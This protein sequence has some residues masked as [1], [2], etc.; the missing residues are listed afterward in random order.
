[1]LKRYSVLAFVLLCSCGT[2]TTQV[3]PVD[4]YTYTVTGR[5]LSADEK[6]K[7]AATDAAA[8]AATSFCGKRG[9][10]MLPTETEETVRPD[11][12]P[13]TTLLFECEAIEVPAAAEEE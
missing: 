8:E 2:V 10:R 5:S 1:M 6:A 12:R 13:E 4:P 3:R 9:K 11:G 7:V